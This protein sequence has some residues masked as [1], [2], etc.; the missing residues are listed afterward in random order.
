MNFDAIQK[1]DPIVCIVRLSN[2]AECKGVTEYT[3]KIRI[4][5]DIIC[6]SSRRELLQCCPNTDDLDFD[7]LVENCAFYEILT[8]SI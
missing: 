6:K 2:L 3:G 1:K 8:L 5:F 4:H 7:K